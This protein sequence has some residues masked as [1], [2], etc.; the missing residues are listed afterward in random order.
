M[1][2]KVSFLS[3]VAIIIILIVVLFGGT[4][5]YQYFE[6]QRINSH[7][8][9]LAPKVFAEQS[10]TAKN[11]VGPR[12]NI[13][14]NA[15]TEGGFNTFAVVIPGVLS[16]S[17]QPTLSE[18][19]WLKN[20]GWKSVVDLRKSGEYN[21]VANDQDIKG[22]SSL[23]F[24]YLWLQIT[25]GTPPTDGQAKKFLTFVKN[26]ANWPV[27]VHC[28]AGVGRAGTLIAL[29]RYQVQGWPMDKAISESKLFNGGVNSVQT[30]WLN[31]WAANN[32]H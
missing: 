1:K 7:I 5:A 10:I 17:G 29:Y 32:P 2:K 11:F 25:D 16:R 14:S 24:N 12:T 22:F 28:L 31:H 9:I 19:Q 21:Q 8:I 26:P 6:I 30:E 23:G 27:E 13:K 20:N 18:F 15:P 3:G 4:F